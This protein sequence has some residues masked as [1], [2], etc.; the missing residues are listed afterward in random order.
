MQNTMSLKSKLI[1]WVIS[2]LPLF[3]FLV[4]VT[5]TF[6]API[7]AFFA[8][9]LVIILCLCLGQIDMLAMGFAIPVIYMVTNILPLGQ[10]MSAYSGG[11][12]WIGI[13]C[14]ILV[15]ILQRIGLMSRIAYFII[16]HTG[17]TYRGFCF[18]MMLVGIVLNIIAP[19]PQ[20]AT[21]MFFLCASICSEMKMKIGNTSAGVMYASVIACNTTQLF[22]YM[23]TQQGVSL[24]IAGVEMSWIKYLIQNAI[25]IPVVVLL[26]FLISVI[27]PKDEDFNGKNYAKMKLAELGKIST[28]EKITA[29][30]MV[31]FVLFLLTTTYTGLDI[32]FGFLLV[33]IILFVA[34]I[35]KAEDVVKVNFGVVMMIGGCIAIGTAAAAV[36]AGT[37]IANCLLPLLGGMSNYVFL[38]FSYIF[39]VVMNFLMT[40]LAAMSSL[41]Q[42]LVDI[43]NS[44]GYSNGSTMLAFCA[45]LE[46]FIFPYEINSLV[47]LFALGWMKMKDFVKFG[48]VKMLVVTVAMAAL[49]IPYWL[50]L[51]V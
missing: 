32:T 40:P 23:P 25:F 51:G 14:F 41:S 7:R 48:A 38:L 35:G 11:I 24:A 19:A 29:V 4:P 39:G 10:A 20:V 3:L 46:Q 50:L 9:T 31:L 2:L 27:L 44:L 8:L 34:G 1:R 43:A 22:L 18:G 42:P 12:V 17:G 36:G 21:V 33:P 28:H 5:D 30:V 13:A 16:Y 45:G 47:T 15:N 37:W 49:V 26:C 6:T